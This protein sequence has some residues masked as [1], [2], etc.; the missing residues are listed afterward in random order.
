MA[1]YS[2]PKI[3]VRNTSWVYMAKIISQALSL[4]ALILVIRKIDVEVFGLFSLY[5]SLFMFFGVFAI[6][7]AV[8]VLRRYLPQ[9]HRLQDYHEMLRV[10]VGAHIVAVL[11]FVF[12][13][14]VVWFS[15]GAIGRVLNIDGF[16]EGLSVFFVYAGCN[17]IYTLMLTMLGSLLLHK[18]SS[19]LLLV[20]SLLRTGCYLTL[21]HH[22]DVPT[23]L[24]IEAV[25]ALVYT[26]PAGCYFVLWFRKNRHAH[27]SSAD[28]Q[29]A[30]GRKRM[31]RYGV[32]GLFNE[33]GAGIIGRTTDFYIVSAIGSPIS[34]GMYAFASKLFGYFSKLMPVN[35][36]LSVIRPVFIGRFTSEGKEETGDFKQIYNLMVKVILPMVA[37]PGLLFL[38]LGRPIIANV[39]DPKYMDAYWVV[40]LVLFM[41]LPMA[42]A[43][44]L[45]LSAE[46]KERMDI[47]FYG[48]IVAFLSI[49]LGILAM[50]SYGVVGVAAVTLI[51]DTLKIMLIYALMRR[52]VDVRYQWRSLMGYGV[53]WLLLSLAFFFVQ[54]QTMP[55]ITTLLAMVI[56]VMLYGGTVVFFH[57][58]DARDLV[59]IDKLCANM[60]GQAVIR[61]LVMRA[62]NMR[63]RLLSAIGL[64]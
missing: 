19:I 35:E 11:M 3:L 50:R 51:C 16:S 47:T 27:E 28:G 54:T 53:S 22:L 49:P 13:W 20:S 63:V 44:P 30:V 9:L 64:A 55:L 5:L 18:V 4:L 32:F 43:I 61:P 2:A 29:P 7:P 57:P 42:F 10:T 8:Q 15:Q 17:G 60:K 1:D 37:F 14:V 33:I 48:K 45:G 25:V 26:V 46:L 6:S 59:M 36:L 38:A 40:V 12:C 21:L 39:F 58:F 41:T 52:I 62:L 23:L 24:K 34:L 31:V 56:F